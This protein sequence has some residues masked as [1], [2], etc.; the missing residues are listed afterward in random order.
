MATR[1]LRNKKDLLLQLHRQRI[2]EERWEIKGVVSCYSFSSCRAGFRGSPDPPAPILSTLCAFPW[3]HITM[4]LILP[5]QPF[6]WSNFKSALNYNITLFIYLAS[7]SFP[8]WGPV[9]YKMWT[10][11][12]RLVRETEI[13]ESAGQKGE[14]CGKTAPY[15]LLFQLLHHPFPT[16][17]VVLIPLKLYC[18]SGMTWSSLTLS[19]SEM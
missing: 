16:I 12:N 13:S 18:Y 6:A 4:P 17:P 15:F 10:W 1:W 11:K 9:P 2:R 19:L 7:P 8:Y 5:I 14:L 3:L